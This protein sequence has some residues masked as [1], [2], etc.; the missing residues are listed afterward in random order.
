MQI[1]GKTILITGGTAGIGLEAA[2]QF[3]ANGA[4]VIITGRDQAKLDAARKIHPSLTAIK[5]DVADADDARALFEQV[6]DLGGIDILYNN[7]GVVTPPLNL[8]VTDAKHFDAAEYEVNVNYLG[9]VRLNDLFMEMLASRNDAAIVNTTSILSYVPL[10]LA[11]TYS[12]TKVALRFYTESL[13]EHLRILG[14]NVKVFELAPPLV[15]TEMADGLDFKPITPEQLV[16]TLIAGMRKD[17]LTI[18]VGDTKLVYFLDRIFP[19]AAFKLINPMKSAER[20]Q[21]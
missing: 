20:L 5:S 17:K 12:A 14:S 18:R 16:R 11:P 13:R 3:L 9:V 4:Q 7:A 1:K 8:G 2:K 6:N 21:A 10:N 15:A 19:R